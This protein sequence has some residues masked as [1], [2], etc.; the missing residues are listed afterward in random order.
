LKLLARLTIRTNPQTKANNRQIITV[1]AKKGGTRSAIAKSDR[2]LAYVDIVHSSVPADVRDNYEGPV[3]VIATMYYSSRRPDLTFDLL[4]DALQAA[5][6][7]DYGQ[8]IRVWDGVYENDRQVS[9]LLIRKKLAPKNP[10]AEVSIY[11]LPIANKQ[12]DPGG[13]WSDLDHDAWVQSLLGDDEDA[14]VGTVFESL[15][16]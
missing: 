13:P 2:A 12:G 6:K 16:Y 1:P 4:Q 9:V 5:Y 14:A 11:A 15:S 8:R 10:R 7:T 3:L